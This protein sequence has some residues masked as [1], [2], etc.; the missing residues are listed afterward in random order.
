[1]AIFMIFCRIMFYNRKIHNIYVV[2]CFFGGI[3]TKNLGQNYASA[4]F[5]HQPQAKP[6]LIYNLS[7]FGF[8]ELL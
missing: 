3:S 5:L 4:G 7:N 1:M 8:I 2:V 6:F